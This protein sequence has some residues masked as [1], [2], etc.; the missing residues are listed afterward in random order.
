MAPHWLIFVEGVQY[1]HVPEI[2]SKN[3]Y[4][5]FWGENLM[6]AKEYPIELPKSKVVYSPHVYGPSVYDMPYFKVNDFP[7]NLPKIWQLHFGYLKDLGYTVVIGEWGGNY[8]GRD[9]IWQDTFSNWLIKKR[10][11]LDDWKMINW[12]KMRVIYKII[13]AAD[14]DFKEPLYILLKTNTTTQVVDKGSKVKLYWYTSGKILKSNFAHSQEGEVVITLNETTTFYIL[15][16]KD[17]EIQNKTLTLYVIE[18]NILKTTTTFIT[19]NETQLSLSTKVLP[20]NK[21]IWRI[22]LIIGGLV[23]ILLFWRLRR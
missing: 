14:P 15:A 11:F 7:K 8:E 17:S 20:L 21:S 4:P 19:T 12:E 16:Q 10:I 1:T 23:L 13:K 18:P 2:D 9:K 22:F 6:G 5:C 3:P